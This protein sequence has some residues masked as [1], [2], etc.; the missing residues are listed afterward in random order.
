M[1]EE[2]RSA[3]VI[4][5]KSLIRMAAIVVPSI[6]AVV[7]AMVTMSTMSLSSTLQSKQA[8]WETEKPRRD[9]AARIRNEL[10]ANVKILTEIKGWQ[11]SRVVWHEQLAALQRESPPDIF[12]QSLRLSH[13]FQTVDNKASRAFSMNLKGKSV[14]DNSDQTVL[15]L[16]RRFTLNEP[17]ASHLKSAEI[18]QFD[19][20]KTASAGSKD[21][22]FQFDCEYKPRKFE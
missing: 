22:I 2:R 14:G 16:K 6:L 13:A 3:S 12:F 9:Q 20:D 4:N 18:I 17:F 15:L 19:E 7:L 1:V 21:R 8:Q 10:A 5:L 11:R